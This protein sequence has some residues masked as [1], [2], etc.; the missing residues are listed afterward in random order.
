MKVEILQDLQMRPYFGKV[1]SYLDNSRRCTLFELTQPFGVLIDGEEH[2]VEKGFIFN[3]SSVPWWLWW[4]YPPSFRPA[5]RG[6]CLHDKGIA[7][8]WK[9]KSQNY[10]D[11]SLRAMILLDGGKASDARRF[12]WAVSRAKRGAYKAAA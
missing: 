7:F 3:G 8:A 10:W 9:S 4:Y 11:R 2:W 6:S 12:Y 1:P 5:F